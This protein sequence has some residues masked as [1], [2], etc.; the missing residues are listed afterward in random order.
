VAKLASFLTLY[1]F[2]MLA[3]YWAVGKKGGLILATG[4]QARG[5]FGNPL[6]GLAHCFLDSHIT[7]AVGRTITSRAMKKKEKKK[8]KKARLIQ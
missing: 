2:V 6:G 8:K 4:P 1:P 5:C 3:R 7:T